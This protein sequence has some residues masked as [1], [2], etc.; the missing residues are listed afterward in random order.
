MNLDAWVRWAFRP[1]NSWH[2]FPSPVLAR[3]AARDLGGPVAHDEFNAA[4]HAAGFQIV[5]RRGNVVFWG[6]RDT[7]A[8]RQYFRGKYLAADESVVHPLA[9]DRPA[10]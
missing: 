7:V 3:Q 1:H 9:S 2:P 4:M 8:K 5:R 6:A 10:S